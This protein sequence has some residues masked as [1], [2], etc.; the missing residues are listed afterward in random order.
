MTTNN[1][2]AIIKQLA[3][4]HGITSTGDIVSRYDRAT[5]TLYCNNRMV[6]PHEIEH[7]KDF[8]QKQIN[9]FENNLDMPDAMNKLIAYKVSLTAVN[10]LQEEIKSK[11]S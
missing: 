10:F 4:A 7:I 9:L 8:L 11:Q 2:E 6:K 5:G 3:L 1:R